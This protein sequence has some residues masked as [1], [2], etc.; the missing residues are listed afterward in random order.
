MRY[1]HAY[2]LSLLKWVLFLSFFFFLGEASAAPLSS[3]VSLGVINMEYT[4]LSI[5][6]S[7][8]S[9]LPSW[10]VS[11]FF[12]KGEF[13]QLNGDIQYFFSPT[14][15]QSNQ[16]RGRFYSGI[17]M[18]VV[19]YAKRKDDEE[20]W[21]RIPLGTQFEMIPMRLQVFGEV[22]FFSGPIPET[23]LSFSPSLGMRVLL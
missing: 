23:K 2:E 17:G 13:I 7:S 6:K 11:S 9:D 15:M 18:R 12:Q 1:K 21:L 14:G 16:M 3:S 5:Q 10:H 20:Y 8:D 19:S 4:G 22:T